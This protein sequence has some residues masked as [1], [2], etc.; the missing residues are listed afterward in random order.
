MSELEKI[1]DK[2]EFPVGKIRVIQL[3]TMVNAHIKWKHEHLNTFVMQSRVLNVNTDKK[4]MWDR[5]YEN[6]GDLLGSPS[7]KGEPLKI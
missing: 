1:P 5:E 3:G 6:F 2:S 4:R 7:M